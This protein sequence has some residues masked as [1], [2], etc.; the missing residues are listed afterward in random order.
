METFAALTWRFG[1]LARDDRKE[2]NRSRRGIFSRAPKPKRRALYK[3]PHL[4]LP[5]GE[6]LG[7]ASLR[8]G[9]SLCSGRPLGR[10]S[11]SHRFAEVPPLGSLGRD[12]RKKR[13]GAEKELYFSKDPHQRHQMAQPFI[14]LRPPLRSASAASRPV[15]RGAARCPRRPDRA[16][17]RRF[18]PRRLCRSYPSY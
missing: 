7:A 11:R 16:V 13:T 1:S 4:P 3:V 9:P 2:K 14:S 17:S 8:E 6:G 12:D 10:A 5:S 18:R 15:G